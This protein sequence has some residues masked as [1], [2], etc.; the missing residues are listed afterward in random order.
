MAAR[1]SFNLEEGMR[2]SS[3][4]ATLALRSRVSMSA[5]GSVIVTVRPPLPTGLGHARHLAGVH[6]LAQADAAQP[7]LAEHGAGPPAAL[8]AG[9]RT[10]LVLRG[11][12][13]LL[14]ERL[15]GHAYCPSRRN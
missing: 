12:L 14:D 4:N 11:P 8:A 5:I 7:E 1:A 15:L 10:D 2:T 9:V 3:W 13:L 6:H